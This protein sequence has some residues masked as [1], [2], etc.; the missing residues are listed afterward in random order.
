MHYLDNSATTRVCPEAAQQLPGLAPA[1]GGDGAGVHDHGVG[2]LPGG[3]GPVPVLLEPGL[4]GLGFK[5]VDLAA[6]SGYN[7]CHGLYPF[8]ISEQRT[9]NR[10]GVRFADVLSSSPKAIP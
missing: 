4:H 3:A 5:L 1:F 2:Q 9:V 8:K 10:Y 7:L 6:E